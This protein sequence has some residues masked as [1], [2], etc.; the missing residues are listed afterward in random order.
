MALY[1]IADPALQLPSQLVVDTSILLALRA[2]DD[3]PNAAVARAFI[4]R[5]GEQA[6]ACEMV[7]WLP[8][9][10]LQECYHIILSS[11]LRRAWEAM[12]ATSRP[13]N[14]LQA[15]KR[16]PHLLQSYIAN[17]E[18]FRR[19]LASIPLTP[20]YSAQLAASAAVEPLDQRMLHFIRAYDLLPQDALIL[21]QAE[22]LD[23]FAIA[24]LDRDWQ[25]A[26]QFDIY[27][28]L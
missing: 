10:V 16:K 26:S 27:T 12:K 17:L 9:P 25:R 8:M 24:T 11:G 15:Y 7:A 19:M 1:D 23:V 2:T 14:W 28:C 21:A 22:Q 13:A 20:I 4:R 18:Y 5:I 3:N 6:L